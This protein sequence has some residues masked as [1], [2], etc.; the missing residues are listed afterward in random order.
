MIIA[1]F[2]K[3]QLDHFRENCN[4]TAVERKV[5]D[6]RSTATPLESIAEQL[7]Y[8]ID[9]IKKVS[10]R[11]NEKINAIHEISTYSTL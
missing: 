10:R 3:P 9:G 5:F 7:G 11:V 4:F 8:S 1:R 2:T 6:L